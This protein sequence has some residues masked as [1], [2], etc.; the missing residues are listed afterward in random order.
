M[1]ELASFFRPC[2]FLI[3][4][5]SKPCQAFLIDIKSQWVHTS[6]SHVDSEIELESIKEKWASNVLA[7]HELLVLVRYFLQ[8][9]CDENTSTLRASSWLDDPLLGGVAPH[10]LLKVDKFI[11]KDK[12]LWDES[13][14][15]GP[16]DFTQLRD[17]AVHKIFSSHVERAWE[18]INF[19]ILME[20]VEDCF[21]D[22][23]D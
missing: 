7:D 9:T 11:W 16:V 4:A 23:T 10:I 1:H 13:K 18:V 21:L 19:L 3:F 2:S 12:G 20:S 8:A 14:V 17:L 22:G 5:S 6:D 15:F